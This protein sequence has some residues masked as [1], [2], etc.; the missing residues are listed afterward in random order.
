MSDKVY[1]ELDPVFETMSLLYHSYNFDE[2]K[3]EIKKALYELGID[4]ER[5]YSQHLK[6][7][8]KYVQSFMRNKIPH[9]ED[10]F[11][12][13]EKDSNYFLV[14]LWLISENQEWIVSTPEGLT[15]QLIN[16]QIIYICKGIFGDDTQVTSF[17]TLEDI[18]Q[19]LENSELEENEKWRLLCFM[20]RPSRYVLNLIQRINANMQAYQKAVRDID[21]PLKKLLEQYHL[22]IENRDDKRFYEIKNK[23]SE[24]SNVYPSMI[25]PISQMMF[26]KSCYYGLLSDR[27]L[28]DTETSL[29]SKK[30]LL[31]RLKALSD[32]S[33]IEILTSLKI[34]PKYNLEIARE[35]GLTAA[36][37]SHHMNVLL[38]CGFVGVEK[39]EGK[40]YY[41]LEKEGI[42]EMLKEI[43]QGLL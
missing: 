40:V 35:M 20:Q 33:K 25:F 16:E 23:I 18:I 7:Y 11:F 37:M 22:G 24:G 41:H 31:M 3:Q 43:E 4:G 39:R 13:G 27:L 17:E 28:K 42:K 10:E 15:D 9:S 32:A 12:F 1:S 14:L 34:S 2:K 29:H 36:T 26:E 38:N 21:K 6:V 30:L 19:I 8:E 5:F